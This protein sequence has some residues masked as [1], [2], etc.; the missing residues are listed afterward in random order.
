MGGRPARPHQGHRHK[1]QANDNK[2]TARI[3]QR[4]WT[5]LGRKRGLLCIR[6][7]GLL[8]LR[9]EK[10]NPE[11]PQATL[12]A[13][14]SGWERLSPE[15]NTPQALKSQGPNKKAASSLTSPE[16]TGG[17]QFE[18][19]GPQGSRTEFKALRLRPH[20]LVVAPLDILQHGSLLALGYCLLCQEPPPLPR[21]PVSLGV[22]GPSSLH[23][24]PG[25][26]HGPAHHAGGCGRVPCAQCPTSRVQ[27]GPGQQPEWDKRALG[28]PEGEAAQV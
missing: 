14:R 7:S 12:S 28:G 21:E 16:C 23:C 2:R 20:W 19:P 10:C 26:C 6:S 4:A 22:G 25:L 5:P 3:S 1:N 18:N 11:L 13:P 8:P 17:P 15:T 27:C 24:S 9:E